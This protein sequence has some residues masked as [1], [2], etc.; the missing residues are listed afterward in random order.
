MKN[1]KKDGDKCTN[2]TNGSMIVENS[3]VKFKWAILIRVENE[4]KNIS[5]NFNIEQFQLF[6]LYLIIIIKLFLIL[7]IL[8]VFINIDYFSFR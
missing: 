8:C 6:S 3:W 7:F 2:S 5:K 4:N 1:F